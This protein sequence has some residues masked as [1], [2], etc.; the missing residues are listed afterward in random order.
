MSDE[1]NSYM[2]MAIG[3][4]GILVTVLSSPS[5]VDGFYK[6]RAAD[7]LPPQFEGL[8]G[9]IR[10]F[11][12]MFVLLIFGFLV[13]LGLAMTLTRIAA[14]M[15]AAR[16][17]LCASFLVAGLTCLAVTAT[18]AAYRS[19]YAV[20]AAVSALTLVL[21][22]VASGMSGDT[23]LLWVTLGVGGLTAVGLGVAA[24]S[25]MLDGLSEH[26]P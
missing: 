6:I 20:P 3:L 11:C 15:G 14:G 13:L 4:V 5:F 22:G 9:G 7:G 18:L 2:Q 12:V 19:S 17:M 1:L 8:A 21:L 16:P 24:H 23:L 10:L 25:G 26:H